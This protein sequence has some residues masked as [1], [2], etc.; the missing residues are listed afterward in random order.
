MM[1]EEMQFFWDVTL[2][3][4]T[5]QY[6][7]SEKRAAPIV[8]VQVQEKLDNTDGFAKLTYPVHRSSHHGSF[9]TLKPCIHP[10]LGACF[11]PAVQPTLL[12][13]RVA[14]CQPPVSK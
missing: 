11:Y 12:H 3:Q 1:L 4:M 8:G 10:E 7:I 2:C 5:K 9:I 13:R 6:C 14:K